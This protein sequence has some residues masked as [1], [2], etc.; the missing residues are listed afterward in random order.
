MVVIGIDGGGTKTHCY[1][2]NGLGEVL[3]EGFGGKANHQTCGIETTRKS[4]VEAMLQAL[5]NA[6]VSLGDIDY[7]VFGLSGADEAMDFAVLQPMC[8]DIM[9]PIPH[10]VVNDTWIGLRSASR[11]GLVSICGT[12]GAHAGRNA[13]GQELILRNLDYLTGNRGGGGELAETALHYAF[14]SNE[15]SF[16]KSAIEEVMPRLFDV[17]TMED[18]YNLLRNEGMS[19]EIAFKIPIEVFRLAEEGDDVASMIIKEMGTAEGQYAAGIIRQLAMTELAVPC[20]LVGSLFATGFPLLVDSYMKEV[21]KVAPKAYMVLPDKNPVYGAMM[22]AV[23]LV[24][25][26]LE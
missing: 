8:L 9:G 23:D 7:A 11:F 16:D 2:G 25:K 1:V 5:G 18:V 21:H 24:E 10:V 14:R 3:G 12:G 6:E 13:Q 17:E 20:V 22:M 4:I 15:G 19:H 26:Y